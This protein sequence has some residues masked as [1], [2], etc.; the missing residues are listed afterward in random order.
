M[1]THDLKSVAIPL[2][3]VVNLTIFVVPVAV[4]LGSASN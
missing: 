1:D 3:A 4:Y 2:M